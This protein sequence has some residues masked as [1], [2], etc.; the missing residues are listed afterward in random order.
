LKNAYP[1]YNNHLAADE[2]GL[3]FLGSLKWTNRRL[4]KP[5]Q[6]QKINFLRLNRGI[7]HQELR[8]KK[9][10]RDG[11]K[12]APQAKTQKITQ[13]ATQIVWEWK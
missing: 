3:G 13:M 6:H 1:E 7:H 5:K 10:K 12:F 11:P 4:G 2:D 8:Q 9:K